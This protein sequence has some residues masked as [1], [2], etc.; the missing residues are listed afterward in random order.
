MKPKEKSLCEITL[1]TYLAH[2]TNE[3]IKEKIHLLQTNFPEDE[4]SR[5]QIRIEVEVLWL[6]K[7]DDIMFDGSLLKKTIRKGNS[8]ARPEDTSV[9]F[10]AIEWL[11][12]N[13]SILRKDEAFALEEE[14]I[15]KLDKM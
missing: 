9:V 14:D 3:T 12:N 8:T 15:N 11:D 13:G 2:E 1:E 6:H 10:Y 7:I 5:P 4:A